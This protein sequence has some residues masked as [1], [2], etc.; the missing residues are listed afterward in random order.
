MKHEEEE[1]TNVY[2]VLKKTENSNNWKSPMKVWA[3]NWLTLS[4]N[5][6]F[7]AKQKNSARIFAPPD[8]KAVTSLLRGGNRKELMVPWLLLLAG[9]E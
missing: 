2:R 5:V 3:Q 7:Q 1:D 6:F 8:P 9:A 4:D